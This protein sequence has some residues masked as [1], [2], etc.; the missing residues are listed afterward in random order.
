MK[1]FEILKEDDSDNKVIQFPWKRVRSKIAADR[2]AEFEKDV[3]QVLMNCQSRVY[4]FSFK[5]K[6]S[7]G[8]FDNIDTLFQELIQ[9]KMPIT[10]IY[11]RPWN[12]WFEELKE[13]NPTLVKRIKTFATPNKLK[14]LSAIMAECVEELTHLLRTVDKN[15]I[16]NEDV[17]FIETKILDF[18][19]WWGTLTA[20]KKTLITDAEN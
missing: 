19:Y 17:N 12:I 7:I 2:L 13:N 9:N 8:G 1:I 11:N 3:N 5:P 16:S 14:E 6:G 10:G 18:R 20:L 4:S 15:Q